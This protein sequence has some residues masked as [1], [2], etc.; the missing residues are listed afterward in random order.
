MRKLLFL[1][2]LC[3]CA[4]CACNNSDKFRVEIA[5]DQL[6]QDGQDDL[7]SL[8]GKKIYLGTFG[9]VN[10]EDIT[11]I[12]SSLIENNRLLMTGNVPQ[13]VVDVYWLFVENKSASA[14]KHTPLMYFVPEKGTIRFEKLS[15][16]KG[17][18]FMGTPANEHMAKQVVSFLGVSNLD[19]FQQE[20]H[21]ISIRKMM[22]AD[23][24]K[25]I[26]SVKGGDIEEYNK[27]LE[28]LCA[29]Y[30]KQEEAIRQDVLERQAIFIEYNINTP[31]GRQM[32]YDLLPQF[33]SAQIETI[34][35]VA[36]EKI[37]GQAWIREH[38]DRKKAE[39]TLGVGIPPRE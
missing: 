38:Q 8:N 5:F 11:I 39:E 25:K 35:S 10:K 22:I 3:M 20:M 1:G 29:P 30:E 33:S 21:D 23:S 7:A 18:G 6:P 27:M 12:D 16:A 34:L 13:E 9:G 15:D 17:F 26:Q 19:E 37:T 32:F 31:F 2:I 36:D 24:L 28:E 4:L 14:R